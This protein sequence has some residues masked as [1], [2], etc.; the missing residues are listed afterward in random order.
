MKVFEFLKK[1]CS[2]EKFSNHLTVMYDFGVFGKWDMQTLIAHC[3]TETRWRDWIWKDSTFYIYSCDD[4]SKKYY[5]LPEFIE[6]KKTD[7]EKELD[8]LNKTRMKNLTIE[9]YKKIIS[10]IEE[11]ENDLLLYRRMCDLLKK[12]AKGR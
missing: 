8:F 12:A 2:A 6:A 7:I 5:F 4:Y 9:R 3:R 11:I 1:T 10:R